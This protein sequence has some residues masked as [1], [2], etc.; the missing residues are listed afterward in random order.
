MKCMYGIDV[1]MYGIHVYM[2]VCMYVC[3]YVNTS[4]LVVLLFD[5]PEESLLVWGELPRRES[6]RGE[7]VHC[8]QGFL[9]THFTI[10]SKLLFLAV[11]GSGALL[12]IVTL[13]RRYINLRNE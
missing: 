11:Q 6:V 12:S 2:Y 1:Y 8:A 3:M 5:K 7:S 4:I 13:K 9:L 10:A